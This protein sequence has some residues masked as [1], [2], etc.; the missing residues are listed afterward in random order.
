[1][2]GDGRSGLAT[3]LP[4]SGGRGRSPQGVPTVCDSNTRQEIVSGAGNAEAAIAGR[5]RTGGAE[6]AR[7]RGRSGGRGLRGIDAHSHS[8]RPGAAA[9]Q[10][11]S[12]CAFAGTRRTPSAAG[13]HAAAAAGC[14]G[15]VHWKSEC[16]TRPAWGTQTVGVVADAS[17][18]SSD[19]PGVCEPDLAVALRSRHRTDFQ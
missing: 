17:G 10:V 6:S 9:P 13:T 2:D 1:M 7:T 15:G 18:S 4:Q 3:E 16:V 12:Q 19:S 14:A 11:D 5:H 8:Q